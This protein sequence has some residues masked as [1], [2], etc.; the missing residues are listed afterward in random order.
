MPRTVDLDHDPRPVMSEISHKAA[1][2]RLAPNVEVQLAK[3]G[4]ESL[5]GHRHLR[6]KVARASDRAGRVPVMLEAVWSVSANGRPISDGPSF[7]P[8]P[9]LPH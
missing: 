2:R 8:I 4:P 3:L 6:P 9:T 5:F 7:H 1:D